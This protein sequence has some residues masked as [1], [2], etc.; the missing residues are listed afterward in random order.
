M[1]IW[2]QTG[3]LPIV[4]VEW[5]PRVA[6]SCFFKTFSDNLNEKIPKL[7][8]MLH[9]K[10]NV[11]KCFFKLLKTRLVTVFLVV[12]RV[13]GSLMESLLF[14]FKGEE[15]LIASKV[16]TTDCLSSGHRRVSC[17]QDVGLSA[18]LNNPW[19]HS[20]QTRKVFPQTRVRLNVSNTGT[21]QIT[22]MRHFTQGKT[23]SHWQG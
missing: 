13:Y 22:L 18:A 6:K 16:S 5:K 15:W 1:L 4:A 11:T 2:Q 8:L 23:W 14:D 10:Y 9:I 20:Q 3:D 17:Q 12:E 21:P 7:N 19:K